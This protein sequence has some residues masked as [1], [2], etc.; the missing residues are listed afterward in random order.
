MA[1]GAKGTSGVS[2]LVK[3]L[4]DNDGRLKEL[5]VMR[6]RKLDDAG[7]KDLCK[8]FERNTVCTTFYASGHTMTPSGAGTVGAMLAV[9]TSLRSLC[10]G[11]EAFGDDAL[12]S[13]ADGLGASCCLHLLDLENKN[14]SSTGVQRLCA[15]LEGNSRLQTLKL[16]KNDLSADGLRPF[17]GRKLNLE[18]LVLQG[19]SFMSAAF[20]GV[21]LQFQ[22]GS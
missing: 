16:S 18:H 4:A 7:V 12:A 6:M 13:L 8:A 11:D 19:C 15:A 3:R 10:I 14:I 9:N 1:W 20:K 22:V 17:H 5:H 21:L 2:D